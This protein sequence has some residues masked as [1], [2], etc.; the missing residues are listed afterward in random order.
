MDF[1]ESLAL[2]KQIEDYEEMKRNIKQNKA[3]KYDKI[4]TGE[5]NREVLL[6]THQMGLQAISSAANS[7]LLHLQTNSDPISCA[8]TCVENPEN[9]KSQIISELPVNQISKGTKLLVN[10]LTFCIQRVAICVIIEDENHDFI[11]LAIYNLAP[12]RSTAKE[13]KQ[14]LPIG[15]KL[16]I[17]EP[18]AKKATDGSYTIR[19]D[20]PH[21]NLII[22]KANDPNFIKIVQKDPIKLKEIGNNYFKRK[23]YDFAVRYYSEALKTA[24]NHSLKLA[25]F[26]NRALCY[27]KLSKPS[28]AVKDSINAFKLDQKSIKT[29]YQYATALTNIRRHNEAMT[30]ING[31]DISSIKSVSTRKEFE[32]LK[33][34]I[35]RR[36]LESTEFYQQISVDE[37]KRMS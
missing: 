30:I 32:K 28:N 37:K 3:S 12:L 7:A 31:V 8:H 22:I 19:I 13:L 24:K 2:K 16:I 35:K 14:L 25:L 1:Q 23:E 26:R 21:C 5:M 36:F 17:K 18:Y 4:P 15:T 20:N 33:N 11:T 27:L 10:T 29:R 34:R 9:L 6:M